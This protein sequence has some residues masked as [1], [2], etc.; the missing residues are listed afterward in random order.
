MLT[1]GYGR[2]IPISKPL[3]TTGVGHFEA[4]AMQL[5][6]SWTT[7]YSRK[8][9]FPSMV[10]KAPAISERS[11]T[12][13]RISSMPG[14]GETASG[15]DSSSRARLVEKPTWTITTEPSGWPA[16]AFR[17]TVVAEGADADDA[18]SRGNR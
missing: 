10:V 13:L 12:F 14:S 11:R 9:A 8:C 2:A 5:G 18:R 7:L 17:S 4:T 3:Q 6:T 15:P 1:D 16:S